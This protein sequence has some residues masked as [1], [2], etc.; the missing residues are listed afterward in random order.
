MAS[1]DPTAAGALRLLEMESRRW[2]SVLD[3]AQDAIISIDTHGRITLFNRAAEEIFGYRA[4]E[5]LQQNVT[6]LMPSPYRDQHDQFLRNYQATGEAK[7]IGRIRHVEAR[8]KSG[9]TFPIELSVSEARVGDTVL[10]SAIVR[11]V[12]ERARMEAALHERMRQQEAVAELGLAAL[13]SDLDMLLEK[14]VALVART[15][16]VEY[17][18][19]LELLPDGT[20]LLLRAGVGW[21]D[22]QVGHA[23][24]AAGTGSQAGYTLL[25][26][27]PVVLDDLRTETRFETPPLLREHGVV[28]GLS[29]V[30][31]LLER[32]YGVLGAHTARHRR[33]SADDTFFFQA[34][35]HIVGEA[36]E[37]WQSVQYTAIQYDV[38]RITTGPAAIADTAPDLLRAICEPLGWEAGDL[39]LVDRRSSVLR[40]HGSWQAAALSS[41]ARAALTAEITPARGEWLPGRIWAS[42]QPECV[43]DLATDPTPGKKVRPGLGKHLASGLGF[44]VLSGEEVIG[45]VTCFS[46]ALRAPARTLLG[47]LDALG[48]QIGGFLRR[49]EIE[50][51]LRQAEALGRQRERL[52]DIGA[53]TARIVHDVG[54]PLAGLS[55][56]TQRIARRLERDPSQPLGSV[57]DVIEQLTQTTRRLDVM[58]RDFKSFAREQRLELSMVD[59]PDFLKQAL[60]AWTPEA[61]HRGITLSGPIT[62]A[63]PSIMADADK[64]RRVFDNLLKNALEAIGQG[65]GEVSL[66]VDFPT[67]EKVR[68]IVADTGPG[69]PAHLRAFSL[70]ETTKPEGTGLGLAIVKE[71]VQAHGGGIDLAQGVGG[72]AAFHVEIP[73]RSPYMPR[74]PDP[75]RRR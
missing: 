24:V 69:F 59:V 18:E 43:V 9:E 64:L 5:V 7:A 8:R 15:L 72:G 73:A 68:F 38:T 37:R 41:G 60:A 33:F 47:L 48:Q 16:D 23:T 71:I 70:F 53:L 51:E 55:M 1:Q 31:E 36:I 49:K 52:A 27:A 2:Q 11:D 21:A 34:I 3:T 29:I 66:S 54:N 13:G 12:S 42:G 30:I 28:S 17:C 10:Y 22:G 58:I 67:R 14:A 74:H 65:P 35:A 63:I 6:M 46:S 75:A 62:C 40:R 25:E 19:L 32:P 45:V 61:E 56:L 26:R 20:T 39:W 44:P 57:K 4:D 50:E